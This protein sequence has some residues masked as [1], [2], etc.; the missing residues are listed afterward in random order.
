M[1]NLGR[2]RDQSL[3]VLILGGPRPPN[4][5][6]REFG[7]TNHPQIDIQQLCPKSDLNQNKVIWRPKSN[8]N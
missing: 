3:S 4:K 6:K 1:L 2:A 8:L 5:K 7:A